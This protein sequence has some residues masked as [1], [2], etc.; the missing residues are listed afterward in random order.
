MSSVREVIGS[1]YRR[2]GGRPRKN[3]IGLPAVLFLL[4]S[5]C[6]RW[7]RFSSSERIPS[8]TPA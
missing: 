4:A 2:T 8:H 6:G 7:A 3:A 1:G 5:G